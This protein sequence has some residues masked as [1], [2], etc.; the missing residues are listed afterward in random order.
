MEIDAVG[1]AS[2]VSS[3]FQTGS[4]RTVEISKEKLRGY[5]NKWRAEEAEAQTVVHSNAVEDGIMDADVQPTMDSRNAK[6]RSSGEKSNVNQGVQI[7]LNGLTNIETKDR[8]EVQVK[9]P[10][11]ES[12]MPHQK[13]GIHRAYKTSHLRNLH[14]I[15]YYYHHTDLQYHNSITKGVF[16]HRFHRRT[17]YRRLNVI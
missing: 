9:P 3:L 6:T 17:R 10:R 16:V 14:R 4:G 8:T 7:N 12:K 15:Q 2:T 1:G 11:D 5:E 13:V